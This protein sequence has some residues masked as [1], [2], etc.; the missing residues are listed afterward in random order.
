[1]GLVLFILVAYLFFVNTR[2]SVLACGI[3]L[4]IATFNG[5][6]ITPAITTSWINI[7]SFSTPPVQLLSL[8]L[9]ALYL[10]FNLGT[11]I[12]MWLD[13]REKRKV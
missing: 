2:L 7:G 3:Y 11:L 1:M 9:L 4:V 5:L 13:F 6:A 8:G 10:V 12:D